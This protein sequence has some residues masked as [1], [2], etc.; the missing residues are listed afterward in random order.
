M[1]GA[2]ASWRVMNIYKNDFA[3]MSE[4]RFLNNDAVAYW[5]IFMPISLLE[6]DVLCNQLLK[7]A[8]TTTKKRK[9]YL[10]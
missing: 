1:R 3:S 4:Y 7:S 8:T 9:L 2:I 6:T 5:C 10:N